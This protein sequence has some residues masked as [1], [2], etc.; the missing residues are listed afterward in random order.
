MRLLP[1]RVVGVAGASPGPSRQFVSTSRWRWRSVGCPS[2]SGTSCKPPCETTKRSLPIS[3][4]Q[5][6]RQG[7]RA[8]PQSPPC[9]TSP[10]LTR[11]RRASSPRSLRTLDGCS[12]RHGGCSSCWGRT[13]RRSPR[14]EQRRRDSGSPVRSCRSTSRPGPTSVPSKKPC[15]VPDET[16]FQRQHRRC[17]SW[18]LARRPHTPLHRPGQCHRCW[19]PC[20]RKLGEDSVDALASPVRCGRCIEQ[21]LRSPVA[22]VR[23]ELISEPTPPLAVVQTLIHDSDAMVAYTAR[24][25]LNHRA[26]TGSVIDQVVPQE[27]W[28]CRPRDKK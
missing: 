3:L 10:P 21:L 14:Q 9:S 8:L 6:S 4:W 12:L 22:W 20:Y 15:P 13:S 11:S 19:R 27:V 1:E 26:D 2:G 18:R 5:R 23:L 17:Q 7:P 28:S 16:A 25:Q 24:W